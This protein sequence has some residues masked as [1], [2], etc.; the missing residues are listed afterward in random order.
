[1]QYPC[2]QHP[3]DVVKDTG[4]EEY[5]RPFIHIGLDGLDCCFNLYII[6]LK[7]NENLLIF[8]FAIFSRAIPESTGVAFAAPG[9]LRLSVE[10]RSSVV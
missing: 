4:K 5:L 1:M 6:L 7:R 9:R 3:C 10:L 8:K 2:I